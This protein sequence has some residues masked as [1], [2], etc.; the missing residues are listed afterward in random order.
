MKTPICDFVKKYIEKDS[1]RL[2]MPGHKG[3][4]KGEA[5]DI[6]EI[7]GADVLYYSD[8]IIKES[9]DCAGKIFG[10]YKTVYST[11]G[12]SLSIR[13]MVYLAKKLGVEKGNAPKI[14]AG[15]NA[16][17]TFVLATALM[18][19]EIGWLFS[20]DEGLTSCKICPEYLEEEI[21]REKPVAVYITSPDYLGNVLDIEEISEV[22][23]RNGCVL[24]V[25]NAHGAYLKFMEKSAHPI[26]LGADI[27]CDSA[28][29]TLPCLTGSGYLHISHNAPELLK[30][31]AE[32]A[33]AMFSSTSPSYLI[34]QSIDRFNGMWEEYKER[35]ASVAKK[36]E[37]MKKE[38]SSYKFIG[39]EFLKLTI[40]AKAYGYTGNEIAD[41]LKDKNIICEFSD[42]DYVVMMFSSETSDED[43][44]KLKEAFLSLEKKPEIRIKP[45]KVKKPVVK[46]LSKDAIYMPKDKVSVDEAKGKILASAEVFC[47]PAIPVLVCGEEIDDSAIEC[48]KYYGIKECSVLF[49]KS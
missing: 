14:L 48:F 29:K 27:C 42:P 6:T 17:K 43:I 33:M 46:V 31:E 1:V 10:T 18:G 21:K 24:M 40:D 11:E 23:H 36:I 13:A 26:D 15:R 39:D 4:G 32:E 34:L 49:D 38:L 25:D 2:H 12:S 3:N 41:Y 47:P 28:H 7:D 20:D 19:V 37:E 5:Y 22:C 16:H 30:K 9:Q 44:E 45:P 8:G 35:V